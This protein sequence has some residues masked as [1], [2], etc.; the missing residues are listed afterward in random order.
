LTRKQC[1]VKQKTASVF[2]LG[3]DIRAAARA[4]IYPERFTDQDQ[5]WA[6]V[7]LPPSV[8]RLV[9]IVEAAPCVLA[10]GA[11]PQVVTPPL[12]HKDDGTLLAFVFPVAAILALLTVSADPHPERIPLELCD[13]DP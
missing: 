12:Q 10:R 7:A 11:A 2:A 13:C 1:P 5:T 8:S 6:G 3:P 4:A 9:A